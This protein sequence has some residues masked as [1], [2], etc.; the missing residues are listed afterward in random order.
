MTIKQQQQ[1]TTT[2]KYLNDNGINDQILVNVRKVMETNGQD[3][4]GPQADI[5]RV[6]IHEIISH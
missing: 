1:L 2:I 4:Q 6:G 3:F 5:G